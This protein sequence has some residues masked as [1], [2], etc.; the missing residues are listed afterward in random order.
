MIADRITGFVDYLKTGR[1]DDPQ[2]KTKLAKLEDVAGET[3]IGLL[4][5]V[6]GIILLAFLIS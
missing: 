3:P 2:G 1:P 4:A 6:A 5:F